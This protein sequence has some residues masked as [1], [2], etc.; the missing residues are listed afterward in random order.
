VIWQGPFLRL[1]VDT[2]EDY[3]RAQ[4]LSRALTEESGG[5]ARYQGETIIRISRKLFRESGEL[6]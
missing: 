3:Q 6:P 5:M 1:T 2:P 4:S